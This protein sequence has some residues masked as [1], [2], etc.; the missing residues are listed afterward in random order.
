M[1]LA[2]RT[3]NSVLRHLVDLADAAKLVAAG[4]R[5]EGALEAIQPTETGDVFA[6][7]RDPWGIALQLVCRARPLEG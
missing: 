6:I 7:V 3:R 5:L 4:G 1:P 2:A